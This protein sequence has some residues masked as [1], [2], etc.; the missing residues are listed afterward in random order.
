[1][2]ASFW[3]LQSSLSFGQVWY[4]SSCNWALARLSRKRLHSLVGKRPPRSPSSSY[5]PLLFMQTSTI[6]TRCSRPC[7]EFY[8][9]GT[10]CTVVCQRKALTNFYRS[11][12]CMHNTVLYNHIPYV[13]N[14]SLHPDIFCLEPSIHH[15]RMTHQQFAMTLT[16]L[17]PWPAQTVVA[18]HGTQ[19]MWSMLFM[20]PVQRGTPKPP[21]DSRRCVR[22]TLFI[23][24]ANKETDIIHGC[25]C[26]RYPRTIKRALVLLFNGKA[27]WN[28]IKVRQSPFTK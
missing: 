15:S 6:Y 11:V 22:K 4:D 8:G 19:P 16:L 2:C 20:F 10:T 17:W 28:N 14:L 9:K 24:M 13:T 5:Q 21:I 18:H 23:T 1:M 7:R 3:T 12:R 27:Q 25:I 26:N